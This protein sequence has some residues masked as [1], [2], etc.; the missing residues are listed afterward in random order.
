MYVRKRDGWD[1]E[2]G[3]RR[4]VELGRGIPLD[5][6]INKPFAG[7]LAFVDLLGCSERVLRWHAREGLS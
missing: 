5:N 1:R 4:R 6:D 3:R 2:E 7:D